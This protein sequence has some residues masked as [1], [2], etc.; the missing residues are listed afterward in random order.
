MWCL[1]L[2]KNMLDNVQSMGLK[3]NGLTTEECSYPDTF[4]LSKPTMSNC[5]DINCF[6]INRIDLLKITTEYF[7]LK[8]LKAWYDIVLN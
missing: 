4:V 1:G 6:D 2:C 7:Q 8:D 3:L 5:F